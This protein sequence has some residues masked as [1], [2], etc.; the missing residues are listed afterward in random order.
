MNR[1]LLRL[2]LFIGSMSCLSLMWR[3]PNRLS[4][5]PLVLL[6]AAAAEGLLILCCTLH[7]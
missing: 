3:L 6:L 5:I 7:D 4:S 2:A 1:H